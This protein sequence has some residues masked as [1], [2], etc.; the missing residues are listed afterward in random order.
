MGTSARQEAR[1]RAEQERALAARTAARRRRGLIAAL[2]VAVL[3]VAGGITAAVLLTSRSPATSAAGRTS[4][5]PW[6]AP[7]D[8]EG[9]AKAA[10]LSMLTAE[11]TALHIHQHLT[12]TIDGGPVT[13]PALIGIDEAAQRISPIHTHDTSGIVHVESPVVTTFHLGQVFAEWDVALG[14]G[15]VGSY[16]DGHDGVH[17]AVFVNRRRYIGDPAGIVLGSRQDIDFVVTTDGSAPAAPTT[18]FV[19]PKGY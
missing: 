15:V 9:R 19:F 14:T 16:R 11:G 2:V 8:V 18:A 10:G 17:E 1:Q 3:V 4:A 12:V 5:P 6:A 7:A 13:V